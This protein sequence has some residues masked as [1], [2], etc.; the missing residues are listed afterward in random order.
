[1]HV[2]RFAIWL[3][4]LAFFASASPGFA[5]VERLVDANCSDESNCYYWRPKLGPPR[6]WHRD[7]AASK[8]NLANVLVPD[9]STYESAKTVIY[10]RATEKVGVEYDV[11]SIADFMAKDRED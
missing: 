8:E 5:R 1:M 3:A 10:V 9:G 7:E 11:K 6:G 2:H 4:T